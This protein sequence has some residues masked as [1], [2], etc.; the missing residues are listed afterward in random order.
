M[1]HFLQ[2]Q[3]LRLREVKPLDTHTIR[4]PTQLRAY[5]TRPFPVTLPA[6]WDTSD[7]MVQST[8]GWRE[9]FYPL[10]AKEGTLFLAPEMPPSSP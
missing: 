6:S 4:K 9:M 2:I 5:V 8:Q 10:G 7:P 1:V 3:K